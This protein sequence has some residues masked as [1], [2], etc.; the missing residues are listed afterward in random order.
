MNAITN[1]PV[2]SMPK[3]LSWKSAYHSFEHALVGYFT[4]QQLVS[5]PVTLYYAF[6]APP[7]PA[8]I[9][10]YFFGAAHETAETTTDQGITVYKITF[11]GVH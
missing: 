11:T 8:D 1:K 5:K 4:S 2:G 6:V 3:A 10:P 7:A 9:H